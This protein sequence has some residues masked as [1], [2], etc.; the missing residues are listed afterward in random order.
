MDRERDVYYWQERSDID[1]LGY[2]W[3]EHIIFKIIDKEGFSGIG[4]A[5]PDELYGETFKTSM[6]IV[7][8]LRR[9]TE[10]FY[11]LSFL[12]D[13]DDLMEKTVKK[14]MA[15]KCAVSL[16]V[17]DYMTGK[18]GLDITDILFPTRK[19]KQYSFKKIIVK[20][21]TDL[22]KYNLK[23]EKIKF[24][25]FEEED[26]D[27]IT[28]FINKFESDCKIIDFRASFDT[29]DVKHILK[30]CDK[31]NIFAIEQPSK[32]G[33][34]KNS[35]IFKNSYNIYWDESVENTE[36]IIRLSKLSSGYITDITK[37]GGI[38]GIYKAFTLIQSYGKDS[39]ISTRIEHPENIKW[40][41]KISRSFGIT[42]TDIE[43]YILKTSK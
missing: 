1:I 5:T 2:E 8:S 11:N 40:T 28:D 38:L 36:D 37:F 26:I 14:D 32:R 10:K 42:D 15:A 6:A 39:I 23:N 18:K 4:A 17:C 7:E 35:E 27:F 16:A 19:I 22:S 13:F 41:K 20:K 3:K 24:E 33:H 30:K 9:L 29:F 25:I 43:K 31:N 34:E 12:E 21:E